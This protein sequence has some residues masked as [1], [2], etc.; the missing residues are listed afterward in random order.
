MRLPRF[1]IA[2][3]AMV[4]FGAGIPATT[5]MA[6]ASSPGSAAGHPLVGSWVADV[7]VEDPGNPPSEMLFHDDGTYLQVDLDR[8][9]AGAWQPTGEQTGALTV[10]FHEPD[11]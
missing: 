4:M 11:P 1:G 7:S 3:L 9:A 2:I 10:I 6:Q 5:V 8:S